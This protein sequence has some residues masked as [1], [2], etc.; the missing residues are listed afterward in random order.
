MKAVLFGLL[1]VFVSANVLSSATFASQLE[2]KVDYQTVQSE[3][4]KILRYKKTDQ[5]YLLVLV[6]GQEIIR[7]LSTFQKAMNIK[8]A[9]VTGLGDVEKVQLAHFNLKTKKM[10]LAPFI[11]DGNELSSLICSL[12]ILVD[13]SGNKTE[14]PH[15]HV[16][17]GLSAE[18]GNCVVGGHLISA[19]VSV[20]GELF[21]TTSSQE[22]LKS[23]DIPFDG[24]LFD[25][26]ALEQVS[27]P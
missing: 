16:N 26:N 21:I 13:Q 20:V 10:D 18:E 4:G 24:N 25:L 27:A 5:G 7:S 8:F 11:E 17:I 19:V 3:G 1:M 23:H 22:I 15:C 9:T 12:S 6:P 2:T 14:L